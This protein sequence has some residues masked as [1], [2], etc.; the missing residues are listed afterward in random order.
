M[1]PKF[2]NSVL[3]G[4]KKLEFRALEVL[5]PS[6]LETLNENEFYFVFA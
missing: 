6:H 1:D 4:L 2:S 5:V 3:T